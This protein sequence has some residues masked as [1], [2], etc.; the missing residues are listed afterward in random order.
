MGHQKG[1]PAQ[2]MGPS[3]GI[4]RVWQPRCL[5]N[6]S[7]QTGGFASPPRGGFALYNVSRVASGCLVIPEP[8]ST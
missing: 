3:E 8:E 6:F 1:G 7:L 2:V 5:G 4:G